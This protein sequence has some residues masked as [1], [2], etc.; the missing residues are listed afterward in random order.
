M[1]CGWARLPPR[2]PG[3]AYRLRDAV[4]LVALPLAV[5]LLLPVLLPAV[6]VML[7]LIRRLERKDVAESGPAPP[8]H[9]HELERTEDHVAQNPFTAIGLVKAGPGAPPHDARRA[10]RPR[11]CQPARLQPRQPGRRAHDPLRPLGARRRRPPADLRQLLRRH[12]RELHGRLHRPAVLGPQRGLQ[13]R[14][15]LSRDPLADPRRGAR[16]RPRSRTTCATTRS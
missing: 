13:Q 16:T 6:V 8:E 15:G 12:P 2:R 9:A 7:L 14:P 10:A 5:L 11:L 1:T 3:L 4:H